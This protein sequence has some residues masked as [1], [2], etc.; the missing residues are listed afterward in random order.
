MTE[1]RLPLFPLPGVVLLPGTLLPLHIFEP[2][3]SEMVA[4]ALEAAG[5]STLESP[6][7]PGT[8]TPGAPPAAGMAAPE[9]FEGVLTP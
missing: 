1:R 7:G 9:H 8:P 4:R 6:T 2:R 5:L 3:Y